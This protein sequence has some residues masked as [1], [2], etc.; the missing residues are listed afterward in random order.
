M[1]KTCCDEQGHDCLQSDACPIY[2]QRR[3]VRAGQPAPPILLDPEDLGQDDELP[4]WLSI[5]I[6]IAIVVIVALF[7]FGLVS[8][9]P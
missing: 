5:W 6:V 4:H 7:V 8:V 1:D 3:R 9:L 2:Q